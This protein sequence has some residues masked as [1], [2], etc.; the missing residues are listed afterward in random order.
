MSQE[1]SVDKLPVT[2]A[3]KGGSLPKVTQLSL[4]LGGPLAA[5]GA[6]EVSVYTDTSLLP[7]LP[8]PCISIHGRSPFPK[9]FIDIR[10][11]A[12]DRLVSRG[13]HA[14]RVWAKFEKEL[15]DQIDI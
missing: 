4:S 9:G 2:A 7:P 12:W 8:L 1:T 11:G 14:A 13:L 15:K 6:P 5:I 10:I 3:Q